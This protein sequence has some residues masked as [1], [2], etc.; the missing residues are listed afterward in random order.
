VNIGYIASLRR[1]FSVFGVFYEPKQKSDTPARGCRNFRTAFG[2]IKNRDTPLEENQTY[3]LVQPPAG[4]LMIFREMSLRIR[5]KP[6]DKQILTC[7]TVMVIVKPTELFTAQC[8]KPASLLH[9]YA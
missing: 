6:R 8:R 1:G 2:F 9:F 4:L 5:Q 3:F 7:D